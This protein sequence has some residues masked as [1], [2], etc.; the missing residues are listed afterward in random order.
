MSLEERMRPVL[1][2]HVGCFGEFNSEDRICRKFCALCIRCAIESDQ[3]TKMEIL[4][5]LFFAE[6]TNATTQ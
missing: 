4:E 3:V 1:E 2:H 6:A 5:D